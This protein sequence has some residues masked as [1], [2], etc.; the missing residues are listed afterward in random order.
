M[1]TLLIVFAILLL[2][3]TLL[4]AFGGSIKYNEQFFDI[5][6]SNKNKFTQRLPG[7]ELFSNSHDKHNK[8]EAKY[9]NTFVDVPQMPVQTMIPNIDVPQMP[10]QVS[11][12][13]DALPP[14]MPMNTPS[15]VPDLE[16]YQIPEMSST[17][18][19]ASI[20]G[21]HFYDGLPPVIS[22]PPFLEKSQFTDT[23][24]NEPFNIEPFESDKHSSLPAIY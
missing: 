3:L 16:S 4:G 18:A 1:R 5:L 19:S 24:N 14:S 6:D 9:H 22:K 12:F 13:L 23:F 15:S 21:S 20:S 17:N 8:Q 7:N 10:T 2:L 11:N